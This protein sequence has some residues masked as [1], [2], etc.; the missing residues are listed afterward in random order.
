MQTLRDA[1]T[2]QTE[3]IERLERR[4]QQATPQTQRRRPQTD[5]QLTAICNY[6]NANVRRTLRPSGW[7]FV[8]AL[9]MCK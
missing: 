1:M 4:A 3:E 2:R 8:Y 5:S 7:I 6:K 9:C